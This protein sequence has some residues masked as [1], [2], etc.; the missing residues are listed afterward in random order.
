MNFADLAKYRNHGVMRN[1]KERLRASG[2]H[3]GISLTIAGLVR[4]RRNATEKSVAHVGLRGPENRAIE[5]VE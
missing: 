3:L 5:C 4:L 2:I 1:W